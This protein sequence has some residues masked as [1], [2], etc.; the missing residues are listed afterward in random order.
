MAA[1]GAGAAAEDGKDLKA[2]PGRL[3]E[4]TAGMDG[5]KQL[6]KGKEPASWVIT[7]D[8]ITHGALHTL[9]SRSYPEHFAERVRWE[10]RRVRDVMI[11]TGI[12]GD[13]TGGILADL[14]WRALRFQ[15]HVVS[16]MFGMSDCTAGA[17]GRESF[18]R[19][20]KTLAEKI[21]AAGAIPLLNSPNSIYLKN[22][23]SRADLPAYADMVR[24]VAE[25]DKLAF[26]DHWKDWQTRKPDQ[27]SLLDWLEDKSIHPGARGHREF[28]HEIFRQ[29]GIFDTQSPTCRLEV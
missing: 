19:N 4:P 16:L 11:N 15:P 8:S 10:L 17:A 1:V 6:L 7:G 29:L 24:E 14:D 12:S 22:A 27:E 28:A 20:L 13:R 25:A 3:V 26:V 2:R 18:R 23:A 5:I 9:G 21:I